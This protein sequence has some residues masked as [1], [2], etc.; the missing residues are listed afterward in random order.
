MKPRAVL[1]SEVNAL[2]L[3]IHSLVGFRY[4]LLRL[5]TG[6]PLPNFKKHSKRKGALK[7]EGVLQHL[8]FA[9]AWDLK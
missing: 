7:C 8:P 1:V 4:A 2:K 6:G 3:S 5:V 9:W